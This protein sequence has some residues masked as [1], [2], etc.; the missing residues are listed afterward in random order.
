[1]GFSDVPDGIE[2]MGLG[3]LYIIINR[4]CAWHDFVLSASRP[5]WGMEPPK[6][7]GL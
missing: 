1:M 4:Y 5:I 3:F 7:R 2:Y 6:D